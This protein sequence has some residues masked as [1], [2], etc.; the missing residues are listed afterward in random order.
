MAA[1]VVALPDDLID[2]MA[3]AARDAEVG[4]AV[5]VRIGVGDGRNEEGA[6][7]LI[8]HVLREAGSG[9]LGPAPESRAVG[10]VRIDGALLIALARSSMDRSRLSASKRFAC[11][12]DSL[13]RPAQGCDPVNKFSMIDCS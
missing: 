13:G 1:I 5:I 6:E 2:A 12:A 8:R 4:P 7:E 9:Q 10:R 11:L 3:N